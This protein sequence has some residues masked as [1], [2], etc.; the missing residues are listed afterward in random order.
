MLY[1]DN[2][3]PELFSLDFA[4]DTVMLFDPERK[5]KVPKP[6]ETDIQDAKLLYY[7]PTNKVIDI[8]RNFVGLVEGTVTFFSPFSAKKK[9]QKAT[10]INLD[11]HTYVVKN[12]EKSLW[13]CIGASNIFKNLSYKGTTHQGTYLNESVYQ[14]EKTY[15][16][17][18]LAEKFLDH[19]VETW[20]L[21]YGPFSSY[22]NDDGVGELFC[23]I[24]EDYIHEYSRFN[25]RGGGTSLNF[26]KY[27]TRVLNF[28]PI[29][30]R[31]FLSIHYLMNVI[32]SIEPNLRNY[33][34]FYNGYFVYSTFQQDA[35]QLFYDYL[36]VNS[37]ITEID[38]KKIFAKFSR[39]SPLFSYGHPNTIKEAVGFLYGLSEDIKGIDS[40]AGEQVEIISD[41]AKANLSE[42]LYT[43]FVWVKEGEEMKKLKLVIYYDGGLV[44]VLGYDAE[45]ELSGEKLLQIKSTVGKNISKL[46]NN[47]DKQ[48]SKL[49]TKEE[50]SRLSYYNEVS[51][52]FRT[53]PTY[54]KYI[55]LATSK[56]VQ[57]ALQRF[58][59]NAER[60]REQQAT[61]IRINK[62]WVVVKYFNGRAVVVCLNA[63]LN[64]QKVEEEKVRLLESFGSN[65]LL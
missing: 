52:S 31:S 64:I 32:N 21:F 48:I 42:N 26:N 33:A 30:K 63:Q 19:F 35:T 2:F 58:L 18:G 12:I 38:D 61:V 57:E 1:P 3:T 11:N 62:N 50:T 15:V 45:K 13:L 55:D 20:T 53:S 39:S 41:K 65:I 29:E 27:L 54:L 47:L 28:A 51:F 59:L 36:Y 16:D 7:Y 23:T 5:P 40:A 14:I 46:S 37:E 17:L 25:S 49:Y 34:V 9:P 10:L 43:P 44:L 8:K 24:I 56:F 4:I 6:I 60:E 22:V